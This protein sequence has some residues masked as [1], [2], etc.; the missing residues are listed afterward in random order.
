MARTPEANWIDRLPP[1][2]RDK[3]H[4]AMTRRRFNAGQPIYRSS[5]VS[6]TIYQV[7]RGTV[8]FSEL[9]A[10]G[11]ET[12]YASA[13]PG[14]CFGLAPAVLGGP[15]VG[16]A[17][18]T[19]PTEVDCLLRADF[20]R[21]RDHYPA[22]DRALVR[23]AFHQMRDAIRALHELKTQDLRCRLASQVVLL[24]SYAGPT[25]DGRERDALDITQEGL[26][27]SVGATR[28]GISKIVREWTDRGLVQYRQGRFCVLD[29]EGL[30][31]VARNEA[32]KD[33]RVRR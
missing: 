13:G 15:R 4:A 23:W 12:L 30:C 31:D 20:D 2:V 5:D 8:L 24:L 11:H 19:E 26:A 6:D 17:V 3:V 1:D 18:P 28:Q 33:N 14:S 16:T 7:V 10:D 32:E 21:L 9:S 27:A 25:S 29:M 22:I